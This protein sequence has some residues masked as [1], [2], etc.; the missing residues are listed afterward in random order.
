MYICVVALGSVNLTLSCLFLPET[1]G[2]DLASV[3]VEE[4]VKDC[5]LDKMDK[6]LCEQQ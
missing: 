6:L 1:K 2:I 5:E 4:N 3:G